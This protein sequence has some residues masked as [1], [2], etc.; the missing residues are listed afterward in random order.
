MTTLLEGME[1]NYYNAN[2]DQEKKIFEDSVVT[3]VDI[4]KELNKVEK[5]QQLKNI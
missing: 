3:D 2:A 5:V 1:T 4:T